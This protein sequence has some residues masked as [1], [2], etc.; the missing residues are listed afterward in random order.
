MNES[1]PIVLLEGIH[2][3]YTSAS[4]GVVLAL[5]EVNLRILPGEFVGVVG[6]SGSGK[7]TLL[8]LLGLLDRPDRGLYQLSGQDVSSL[9]I[10]QQ[11]R[12]RN[13]RIGFVFQAFRLLPRASALENVELPLL[14][15]D[16]PNHTNAPKKMLEE[17]GLADRM[18]HRATEL[19]GGQQQ[20]VAIARA[21]VNEP[22][23]LL[24]D[25]PTGNLDQQAASEIFSIFQRLHQHGKTIVLVTHD[26]SLAARCQRVIRLDNGTVVQEGAP[27]A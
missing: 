21:L 22:D 20:R 18:H 9:T 11:A 16:R 17:V 5:R 14:Y 1:N 12:V 24:A 4:R 2:R 27:A 23:L 19:S 15:S 8:N 25:E 3:T 10:T 7:S 13:Q 6:S 26:P